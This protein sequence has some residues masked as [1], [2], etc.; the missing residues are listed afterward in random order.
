MIGLNPLHALFIDDPEQA[1]PYAPARRLYLNILNI[2]ATSIR[3]FATCEDA[4]S[5]LRSEDFTSALEA[6]R[7]KNLVNYGAIA[8]LKL[9]MLRPIHSISQRTLVL[10][11]DAS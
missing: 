7:A 10:N 6:V 5:L 9:R 11:D 3:E 2:D 1:S 4:K 8:E